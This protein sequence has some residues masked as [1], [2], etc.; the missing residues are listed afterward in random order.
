M[1][2]Y[3]KSIGD[4]EA[5]LDFKL[6]AFHHYYKAEKY[7]DATKIIIAI[8]E[9]L[10][11]KGAIKVLYDMITNLETKLTLFPFDLYI[12][13]A[14]IFETWGQWK[15]AKE[16]VVKLIED[17]NVTSHNYLILLNIHFHILAI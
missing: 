4:L 6:E 12:L 15:K 13:K 14:R 16:I 7:D 2:S 17:Y 9:T 1:V 3:N 8:G 5:N 11:Q 10:E